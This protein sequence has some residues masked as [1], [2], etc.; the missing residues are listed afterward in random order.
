MTNQTLHRNEHADGAL[1]SLLHVLIT[2]WPLLLCL[3]LVSIPF[4]QH[5]KGKVVPSSIP[6]VAWKNELFS[7]IRASFRDAKNGFELA[8]EGYR[9]Y[10]KHGLAFACVSMYLQPTVTLPPS[11]LQ[12]LVDQPDDHV[13]QPLVL[14]HIRLKGYYLP[15][16]PYN[17]LFYAPF[18]GIDVKKFINAQATSVW[19]RVAATVDETCSSDGWKTVDVS[20]LA[21]TVALRIIVRAFVGEKLSNDS[22]FVA[23][24]RSFS[25]WFNGTIIPLFLLVPDFLKPIA[26]PV[27]ARP[28][29]YYLKRLD[30]KLMPIIKQLLEAKERGELKEDDTGDLLRCH[31]SSGRQKPEDTNA[32]CIASRLLIL[33]G[34]AAFD[35]FS[36]GLHHALMDLASGPVIQNGGT[37]ETLRTTEHHNV[38]RA[39]VQCAVDRN[40]GLWTPKSMHELIYT[41]SFLREVMRRRTFLARQ[42]Y[43]VVV[44]DGGLTLPEQSCSGA[45]VPK[46]TWL[47]VSAAPVHLDNDV[48]EDAREFK[49]WRFV[50]NTVTPPAIKPQGAVAAVTDSFLSFGKGRHACPGRFFAGDMMK[51]A[52]A[53]IAMEYDIKPLDGR[54]QDK[55]I[56]D[57]LIPAQAKI[58]IRRRNR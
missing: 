3:F 14:S 24:I 13:A 10:N 38:I 22:T 44:K 30:R 12:W 54:P 29:R 11:E 52:I 7:V 32:R 57:T 34:A 19:Q 23:D 40:G 51:L 53:Y 55:T 1:G 21:K 39:E 48:W 47:A 41:E 46:G 43:R 35:T 31:I 49:A 26:G 50:D 2:A 20:E 18:V 5:S 28:A 25:N 6:R 4:Y 16:L 15:G 8:E 37:D 42:V 33:M 56:G 9:K 27:F 36:T 17:E 45:I 58:E